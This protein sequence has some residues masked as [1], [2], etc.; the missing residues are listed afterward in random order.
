MEGMVE[1]APNML[2]GFLV[3][4]NKGYSFENLKLNVSTEGKSK[5]YY[6][7]TKHEGIVW[8]G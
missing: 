7:F 6:I 5:E 8:E 4:E 1:I 2:I 3:K